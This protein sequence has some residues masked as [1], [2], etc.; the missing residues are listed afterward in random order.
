MR[1]KLVGCEELE[2]PF[3]PACVLD[4]NPLGTFPECPMCAGDLAPEHA[5]F[6]CRTCGW[7]DSCC[8]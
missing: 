6:R 2:L 8:D 3:P 5:H 4:R 1:S 7:R